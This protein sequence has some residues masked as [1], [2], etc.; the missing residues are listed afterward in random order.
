MQT[1]LRWNARPLSRDPTQPI[2]GSVCATVWPTRALQSN[3]RWF[4]ELYLWTEGFQATTT[5]RARIQ[6]AALENALFMLE[7]ERADHVGVTLSF[8]TIEIYADI[9]DRIF[10]EHGLVNHRI[11]IILRGSVERLRSHYRLHSFIDHLREQKIPVGYRVTTPRI[12]ME[13]GTIH[14]LQPDF[15][16]I[17]APDSKGPA[18]WEDLV[19]GARVAAVPL[20]R[21]IVAGLETPEQLAHAR[22]AE[23]GFGQ[24]SAL[25]AAFAPSTHKSHE[26]AVFAPI[27]PEGAAR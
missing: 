16:K 9:V 18:A 2:E 12:S 6:F 26:S 23:I 20:E 15:V 24:G 11:V 3:D 1:A 21:L 13:L 4:N 27:P 5:Q 8:G 7:N 19:A 14:F 17:I 10:Q 22:Q 25:R